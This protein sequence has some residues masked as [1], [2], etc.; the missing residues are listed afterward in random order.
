MIRVEQIMIRVEQIMIRVGE[1]DVRWIQGTERGLSVWRR[2]IP[3]NSGGNEGE[4]E[5]E[6][7]LKEKET[8]VWDE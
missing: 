8:L 6:K 1:K 4:A 5:L 2:Q 7:P 3:Q